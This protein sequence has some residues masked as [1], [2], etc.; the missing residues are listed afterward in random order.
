MQL[1]LLGTNQ[2][3]REKIRRHKWYVSTCLCQSLCIDVIYKGLSLLAVCFKARFRCELCLGTSRLEAPV[4]ISQSQEAASFSTQRNVRDSPLVQANRLPLKSLKSQELTYQNQPLPGFFNSEFE[5][6]QCSFWLRIL[7]LHL[8]NS[9][10]MALA[11]SRPYNP[12]LKK[13]TKLPPGAHRQG[14]SW[15]T[16]HPPK[17]NKVIKPT[18]LPLVKQSCHSFPPPP[19]EWSFTRRPAEALRNVAIQRASQ[20]L[21]TAPLPAPP[22]PA[23]DS[24]KLQREGS[25]DSD[26][27]ESLGIY[28]PYCKPQTDHTSLYVPSFPQPKSSTSRL[29][30]ANGGSQSRRRTTNW[31]WAIYGEMQKQR[32]HTTWDTTSNLTSM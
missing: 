16:I 14:M 19:P 15:C 7:F 13:P 9:T 10:T 3:R 27:A 2:T 31:M 12:H 18:N 11:G 8:P 17:K 22:G 5:G 1:F 20:R 6:R 25:A 29:F 32:T 4:L 28:L 26:S 23:G 21:P 30:H 24:R